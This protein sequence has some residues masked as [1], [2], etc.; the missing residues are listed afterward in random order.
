M[1]IIGTGLL[2]KGL[3]K[4]KLLKNSN[5]LTFYAAG[6]SNSNNKINKD[7]TRDKALLK[8]N[9]INLD[10]KR[11]LIYFS[12]LSVINSNLKKDRYVKNKIFIEKFIKNN[13][14]NYLIIRLPQI[15]GKSS[16]PHTLT[17][18]L[19]NK[20]KNR[21]QF[22]IWKKASRYL[23]DIDDV[24]IILKKI[25]S[26][27]YKLNSIIN[28]ANLRTDSLLNIVKNFE[29]ILSIK[30]LFKEIKTE[31]KNVSVKKFNMNSS[32]DEKYY[33][34]INNKYYLNKILRKY[35]K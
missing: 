26:K 20:I 8:K 5:N 9:I 16:N 14:K 24:I 17:N 27:N 35:Y 12:S 29:Q 6:V 10:K 28:I 32:R 19:Y 22:M 31:N 23:I 1:I 25:L 3:K 11:I 15:I 30:A 7:Y 33:I 13:V 34:R 4:I 18:F 21:E 2:A